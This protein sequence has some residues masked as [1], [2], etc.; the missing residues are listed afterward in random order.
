MVTV[1][2]QTIKE[3]STGCCLKGVNIM[4]NYYRITGYCE[5]EDFC[6]I[7]DCYGMFDSVRI[8]CKKA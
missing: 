5:S 1:R 2:K 3:N 4:N 8:Y 7:M 6:F